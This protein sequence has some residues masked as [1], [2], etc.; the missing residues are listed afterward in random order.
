MSGPARKPRQ[1]LG[2]A[3]SGGGCRATLFR[4][5]ALRRLGELGMLTKLD[6]IASVSGG[7]IM[8]A[9]LADAMIASATQ[10]GARLANFDQL[11]QKVHDLTSYNLRRRI[12]LERIDPKN[13][14]RSLAEL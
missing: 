7:S 11:T 14:H 8:S 3:P 13:W 2:L 6:E 1:G 9:C 10:P 4:R 12:L 5:V